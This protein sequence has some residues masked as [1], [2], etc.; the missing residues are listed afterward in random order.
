MAGIAAEFCEKTRFVKHWECV[1]RR[2]A[3][4]GV[5]KWRVPCK[6][7]GG[8]VCLHHYLL[9]LTVLSGLFSNMQGKG[10]MILNLKFKVAANAKD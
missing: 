7:V 1:R 9:L 6:L 3:V 5:K 2:V 4:G 10:G 8:C